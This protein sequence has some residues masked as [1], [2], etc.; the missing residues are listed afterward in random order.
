MAIDHMTDRKNVLFIVIDQLRA[1]VLNGALAGFA[2]TPNLDAFAASAI[3][4]GNHFSVTAPCGPSRA[5]LLTGLY[6]MNHRAIRNGTP[7]ASHHTNLALEARKLGHEPLLFG[8][9]DVQPDPTGRPAAD[10]DN[11][12]YEN[13]LPGFREIVEMRLEYGA[14]WLG[15]LRARGYDVPDAMSPDLMRLYRPQGGVFGNP[16]LY[17]AEDS[18][19]AYLT[20]RTIAA[21]SVR[22]AHPFFAHVTYVRPHP[23]LVAPAPYHNLVDPTALPTPVAEVPDHAFVEAWFSAPSQK[24]MFWDF[25]GDCRALDAE[26]IA[27]LRATYLGLVAEVDHHFGRL[28]SFLKDSGLDDDTLVVVT[29]D[30]GE[31]LGDHGMWGKDTVFDPAYRVPLMIRVPGARGGRIEALTE[32]VD[33]TPTILDWLGADLPPVFDG[34]SLLPFVDTNEPED[35]RG[36]RLHGN[37]VRQPAGPVAL[38]NVLGPAT[39]TV[40]GRHPAREALEIRAFRRRRAANAVQPC[41]RSARNHEPGATP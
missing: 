20:D 3:S 16:A 34:R 15:H 11:Y 18:D 5:S 32:S 1:D 27:K 21:L 38:R 31:M 19:T 12:V 14:E 39:R 24:D 6:A 35:W 9:T 25:D 13:V 22:K 4:F 28:M 41:R 37:R 36:Q 8:Y 7:L 2:P 30:H 23:P 10:P 17:S 40:P 33:V 29:G 26:T